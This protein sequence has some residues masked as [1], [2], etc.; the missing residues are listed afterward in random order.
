MDTVECSLWPTGA[1]SV[2]WPEHTQTRAMR[3]GD[4]HDTRTFNGRDIYYSNSR[5][6]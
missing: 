2:L 1:V 5:M 3:G 4:D 6:R